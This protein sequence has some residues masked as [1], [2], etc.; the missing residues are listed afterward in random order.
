MFYK[1]YSQI[2]G[3]FTKVVNE[4][5]KLIQREKDN[6]SKLYQKK[7]VINVALSASEEEV[8]SA[9][10]TIDKINEVIL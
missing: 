9:S 3:S 8:K 6:S 5:E 7:M 4:L 2:I 10:K 1:N